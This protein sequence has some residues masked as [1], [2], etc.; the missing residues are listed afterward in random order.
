MSRPRPQR[1]LEP[2][3]DVLQ[4]QDLVLTVFGAHAR[5]PGQRVWSGGMV[6]LLEGLDFT[7]GAA[8]T[9][10]ARL[11]KRDLLVRTRHGRLAFYTL[12]DRAGALLAEGDRRIF[13]FARTQDGPDL[14]T[15][16][17]HATPEDRRIVRARL[18]SRLRFLGFDTIQS[19]T[20]VAAHNRE[21][22]VRMLLHE[23]EIE[24]HAVI[25]TGRMTALLSLPALVNRTWDLERVR[26][27]YE[28]F[29]D[30]FS[31]LRGSTQSHLT[32]REAFNTRTLL[33]HRFRMFPFV[34]PEL[35]EPL[36]SIRG[37]RADVLAT[38]DDLHEGLE[39][40]ADEF[41]WS[42]VKDRDPG[43]PPW[44]PPA[45]PVFRQDEHERS[46]IISIAAGRDVE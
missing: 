29:L 28:S 5:R 1:R 34:D 31:R 41:F 18:S 37:L 25:V 2:I 16:L 27:L 45:P 38:F 4:P 21:P 23:L 17:W 42:V 36:D 33:L 35:P 9:A 10:L 22:E 15:L 3:T 32:G 39:P 26:R 7:T 46:S 44:Q 13:T 12:T 14:W 30:D 20:W 24:S 6:N 8:R 40:A 43:S 19:G 11:V